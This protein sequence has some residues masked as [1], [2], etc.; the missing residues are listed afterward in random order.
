MPKVKKS[1]TALRTI[2]EVS[3]DLGLPQH[4]LRFWETKF[5]KL[6]PLKRGGGRRYYRPE[7]QDLLKNIQQLLHQEGYTIKGV[8]NLLRN[9]TQNQAGKGSSNLS[10]SKKTS[11]LT[12][13]QI[14]EI[15][16]IVEEFDSI[17]QILD[18]QS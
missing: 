6:N 4:V 18:D 12:N 9:K 8:Q 7:D 16:S 10:T 14:V 3:S 1:P 13:Q 11:T 2:S 15:K 5:P 17:K